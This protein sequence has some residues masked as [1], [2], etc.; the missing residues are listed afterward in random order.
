VNNFPCIVVRGI[1][2][3]AD[4]YKNKHWQGYAAVTRAAYA[5]ELLEVIPS[6]YVK[7]TPTTAKVIG[8]LGQSQYLLISEANTIAAQDV[9]LVQF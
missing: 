3:Y 8:A 7:T 6:V 1:C 5:K 4:S 9:S 2:D